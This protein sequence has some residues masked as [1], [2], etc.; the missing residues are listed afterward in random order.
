MSSLGGDGSSVHRFKT[1]KFRVAEIKM[2]PVAGS[3]CALR[4]ASDF[5]HA[6][7]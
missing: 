2:S 3:A 7:K 4:K 5:V 6:V 1:F